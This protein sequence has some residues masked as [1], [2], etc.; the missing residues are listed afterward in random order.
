MTSVYSF[1]GSAVRAVLAATVCLAGVAAP[2]NA[3]ELS[4]HSVKVFM[5][6]A[7]GLVPQ[8]FTMP[9]GKT[10][11]VDKKRKEEVIVP[12]DVAREVIR[13]G[14]VSAY[15]QI[16]KLNEDQINNYNSLMRREVEKKKWTDQQLIYISQLHLTT[17][18][19]LTGRIQLIDKGSG[20]GG[21]DIV[22]VDKPSN[23]SCSP[24]QGVKIK[25]QIAAYVA[26][27]PPLV[28]AGP[29]GSAKAAAPATTG[30]N[31]A[32]TATP[33]PVATQPATQKK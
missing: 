1:G 2:A 10:I 33:A 7:W 19:L 22:E 14:R 16:C 20:E 17:M 9:N 23:I 27:G 32:A 12:I 31:P 18:M 3:Q 6:Y 28:A 30:S 11:L 5:D 15:A 24:E 21:K 13:V 25:E 26:A 4:E 8:Q 29:A